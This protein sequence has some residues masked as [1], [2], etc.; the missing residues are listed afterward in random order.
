VFIEL[1][2]LKIIGIYDSFKFSFFLL[3]QKETKIQEKT[4]PTAQ[5]TRHRVFLVPTLCFMT[6][7]FITTK[8]HCNDYFETK[9]NTTN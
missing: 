6:I 2:C 7:F 1:L 3:E 4:I 8:L 5:A 9:S